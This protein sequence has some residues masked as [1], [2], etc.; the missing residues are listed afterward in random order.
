MIAVIAAYPG[1]LA[2]IPWN[3]SP[4]AGAPLHGDERA[5]E[6]FMQRGRAN[7]SIVLANSVT[8]SAAPYSLKPAT[9]RHG[10]PLTSI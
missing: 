9:T 2:A 10:S 1:V 4:P 3:G 8:A 6:R 7:S 5:I